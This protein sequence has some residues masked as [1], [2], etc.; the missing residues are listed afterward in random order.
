MV[1][2]HKKLSESCT[3]IQ[4]SLPY[5]MFSP[6]WLPWQL[7][8]WCFPWDRDLIIGSYWLK[9]GNWE[10]PYD[11]KIPLSHITAVMSKT[12]KEQSHHF[13]ISIWAITKLPHAEQWGGNYKT[14]PFNEGKSICTTLQNAVYSICWKNIYY[15]FLLIIRTWMCKEITQNANGNTHFSVALPLTRLSLLCRS[16]LSAITHI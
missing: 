5:F 6:N 10:L 9:S 7:R 14:L 12:T 8:I 11:L 2:F 13:R 3:C 4:T 15:V 16:Q 1:F